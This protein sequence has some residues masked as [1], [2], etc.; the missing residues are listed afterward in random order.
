[1]LAVIAVSAL[2]GAMRG[3]TFEVLSLAGWFVAWFAAIW[4][5]PLLAPWL[6]IGAA[7]SLL[8]QGVAFASVFLVVLVLWSLAARAVSGLIRATPL[9]PVDRLLGVV[10]GLAR[11]IVVLVAI[12][13]LVSF[14]PV[15]RSEAWAE[16]RGAVWLNAALQRLLPLVPGSLPWRP[17]RDAPPGAVV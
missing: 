13:T 15:A 12:T 3:L 16:S 2:V 8:N 10:F 11:A 7:G 9:R 14:T 6:P 17:R 5:G 4:F 1:M